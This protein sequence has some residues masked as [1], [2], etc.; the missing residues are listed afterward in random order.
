MSMMFFET[1]F[2]CII[3]LNVT[4]VFKRC[5]LIFRPEFWLNTRKNLM[6]HAKF[7]LEKLKK[8]K[9]RALIVVLFFFTFLVGL[10]Q[11]AP[12]FFRIPRIPQEGLIEF[13]IIYNN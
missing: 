7:W 1:I 5:Q 3:F 13:C 4:N 9:Q 8:M 6:P 12:E 11:M 10:L 2:F